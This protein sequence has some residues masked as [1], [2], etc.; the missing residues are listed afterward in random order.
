MEHNLVFMKEFMLNETEYVEYTNVL[1]T[2]VLLSTKSSFFA[3]IGIS[4]PWIAT[5]N[6]A[7]KNIIWNMSFSIFTP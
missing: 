6:N 1:K 2:V 3:N 4:V 7:T 5:E